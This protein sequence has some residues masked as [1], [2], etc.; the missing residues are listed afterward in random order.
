MLCFVTVILS[1]LAA[2]T[3]LYA[4]KGHWT[5]YIQGTFD[6]QRYIYHMIIRVRNSGPMAFELYGH[7][8]YLYPREVMEHL[9]DDQEA[10]AYVINFGSKI[11]AIRKDA[12]AS[13]EMTVTDTGEQTKT[14]IM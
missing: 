10:H 5:P 11:I 13:M 8:R 1:M 4:I 6:G 7:E 14:E 9:Y 12:I 3:Y 2:C